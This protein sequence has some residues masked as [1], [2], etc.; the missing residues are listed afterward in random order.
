MTRMTG[1]SCMI[2]VTLSLALGSVHAA[3]ADDAPPQVSSGVTNDQP[4]LSSAKES[5]T[6]N[7]PSQSSAPV[8]EPECK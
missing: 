2:A 6:A 5:D 7:P 1:I 8:E 4:S 3:A